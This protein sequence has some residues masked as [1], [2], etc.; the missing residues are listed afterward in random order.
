MLSMMLARPGP[1]T[2]GRE[3]V[4]AHLDGQSSKAQGGIMRI[5]HPGFSRLVLLIFLLNILAAQ[6][7]HEAGHWA[8]LRAFGR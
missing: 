3:E 2:S 5:E 7:L 4:G 8:I 6:L 1:A